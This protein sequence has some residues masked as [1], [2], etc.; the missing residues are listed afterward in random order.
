MLISDWRSDVCSSDLS[1]LDLLFTVVF[2]AVMF[3]YSGWLTLIVVLALPL[4]ALISA[5]ITPSL[6]R[7]LNEKFAR[8]ADNQA[9][10]VET[11][12]GI[13]TVKAMAVEPRAI[14]TWDQQLAAYVAAGFAVTR[15]ALLGQQGVQLVHKGVSIAILFFGAQLVIKGELSLGQLIAFNMLAGQVA[16]P[17]IC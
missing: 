5:A 15:V 6:R 9:F 13:G 4:Y 2:L 10:L 11:V 14:G 12:T 7:R 3:F 8:G 1:V 16:A 17:I